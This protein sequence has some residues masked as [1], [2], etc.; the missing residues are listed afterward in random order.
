MNIVLHEVLHQLGRILKGSPN[1]TG[2][3]LKCFFKP[4]RSIQFLLFNGINPFHNM[5]PDCRDPTRVFAISYVSRL[6]KKNIR[7]SICFRIFLSRVTD[8]EKLFLGEPSMNLVH[9][10]FFIFL[11][12]EGQRR[13][14]RREF[15]IT[16]IT[17]NN[18]S[19]WVIGSDELLQEEIELPWRSGKIKERRVGE[20]SDKRLVK[21][22][23]TR[24]WLTF[25]L[26]ECVMK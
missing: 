10:L 17:E 20:T 2:N 25:L 4:L 8:A 7:R 24:D 9:P 21:F 15:E 16:H 1:L 6:L 18:L 23:H 12:A 11:C 26:D 5:N 13:D 19:E 3:I 22:G 14:E